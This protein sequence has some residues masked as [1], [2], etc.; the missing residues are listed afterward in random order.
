MELKYILSEYIEKAMDNAVYEDLEEDG[1]AG[2]I[3]PCAGVIGFAP[4]LLECK[5]E[6][7]SVLEDWMLLG[8]RL[9]HDLPV[10]DGIDLN[11]EAISEPVES[12]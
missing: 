3:P 7:R 4:T 10:V 1:F 8:F 5:Q 12:L 6:L 11:L 9:G 2:R